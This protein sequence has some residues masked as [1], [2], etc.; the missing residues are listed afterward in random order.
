MIY[1]FPSHAVLFGSDSSLRGSLPSIYSAPTPL[2]MNGETRRFS[3]D[4]P[5]QHKPGLTDRLRIGSTR[6]DNQHELLAEQH[7][8]P[9]P[10]AM[11]EAQEIKKR[12]KS[13]H[14]SI[15]DYPSGEDGDRLPMLTHQIPAPE[16]RGEKIRS[17]K[18]FSG[19]DKM[20][21]FLHHSPD[22]MI[23][24]LTKTLSGMCLRSKRRT[25]YL[26]LC[27]FKSATAGRLLFD[28]EICKM[29]L[30][31]LYG[32]RVTRV[33]GDAWL[34]K[35]ISEKILASAKSNHSVQ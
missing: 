4:E 31:P 5:L 10:P 17:V 11:D 24:R 21:A 26:F 6:I 8:E 20:V 34:Y 29:W 28:V 12:R 2:S 9:S 23:V 27:E 25:D 19:R 30:L 7:N 1:S 22:E 16:I 32:V 13:R 35:E 14:I 15:T 3:A 18:P 33:M